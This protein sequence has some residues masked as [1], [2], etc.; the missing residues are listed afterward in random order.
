[1]GT[2][3]FRNGRN[4][5]FQTGNF[6]QLLE[7][8]KD[9]CDLCNVAVVWCLWW[10]RS[11]CWAVCFRSKA[12]G[13]ISVANLTDFFVG[14][15]SGGILVSS[16]AGVSWCYKSVASMWSSSLLEKSRFLWI[17]IIGSWGLCFEHLGVGRLMKL[18]KWMGR[19]IFPRGRIPPDSVRL[20]STLESLVQL[21]GRKYNAEADL[22]KAGRRIG[23]L[24]SSLNATTSNNDLCSARFYLTRP[25]WV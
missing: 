16:L 1:M 15:D 23:N 12:T 21:P 14:G 18:L 25:T 8:L 5:Y 19:E 11:K 20:T 7:R 24:Q 3:I 17:G 6:I 2:S 4:R 13:G 9:I 10:T 22:R